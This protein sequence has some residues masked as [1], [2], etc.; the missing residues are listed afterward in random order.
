[1]F[2]LFSLPLCQQYARTD[3]YLFMK[4]LFLLFIERIILS[5]SIPFKL[6][7]L[8]FIIKKLIGLSCCHVTGLN[9]ADIQLVYRK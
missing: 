2:N 8:F 1:M 9:H 3:C 6:L 5:N 7:S 4:I